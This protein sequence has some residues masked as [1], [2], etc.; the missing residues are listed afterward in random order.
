MNH[1]GGNTHYSYMS[2]GLDSTSAY[3]H[4]QNSYQDD[5][6]D[7]IRAARESLRLLKS[8][9]SSSKTPNSFHPHFESN[10]SFRHKASHDNMGTVNNNN[11]R[12]AFKPSFKNE[13]DSLDQYIDPRPKLPRAPVSKGVKQTV[14]AR[15]K[16]WEQVRSKYSE[17]EDDTVQAP[18]QT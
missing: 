18:F 1:A 15:S 16:P 5:V 17:D 9:M 11:Y 2:P 7:E 13:Q 8:K 6:I 3:S 14:P 4:Q 12:K 10:P